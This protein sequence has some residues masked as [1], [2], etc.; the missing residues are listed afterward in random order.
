MHPPHF[1]VM[2]FERFPRR[3]LGHFSLSWSWFNYGHIKSSVLRAADSVVDDLLRF[4]QDG[5]QMGL[6]L[7]T[8]GIDF[9]NLFGAGRPGSEP[10]ARGYHLQPADRGV[11]S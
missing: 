2:S 5:A 7:K 3:C 6:A 9:A 4:T 11:V 8:L 1:L 10:A